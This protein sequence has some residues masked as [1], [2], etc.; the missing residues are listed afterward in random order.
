MILIKKYIFDLEIIIPRRELGNYCLES[1]ELQLRR[2]GRG[3]DV[4]GGDGPTM[5]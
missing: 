3:L 2:M 1:I 5:A 4:D